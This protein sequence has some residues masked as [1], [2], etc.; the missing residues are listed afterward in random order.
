MARPSKS[1]AVLSDEG[2]SHRTKAEM[3]Q[4][5]DAEKALVT[6]KKLTERRE[7]KE[8]PI[9]HREFQ[10]VA[11]LLAAIKKNDAL[12]EPIINRYCLLQAE[13][14]DLTEM[15]DAFRGAREELQEE[16]R[17]GGIGEETPG[18]LSPSQYYRLLATMQG[19][20][21]ALDKQI[22]SKRKMI[23]DIEKECAMTISAAMRSIPKKPEQEKNPLLGI[24]GD[25][26][27]SN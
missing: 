11:K 19:N 27:D 14:A 26:P 16:Y 20:V 6:G 1:T 7:V 15:R 4:R 21:L 18:G 8:N 23:F 22:Q 2:R 10:R 5:A 12:Y 13:C 24:L 25:D 9:A 3:Q 17:A